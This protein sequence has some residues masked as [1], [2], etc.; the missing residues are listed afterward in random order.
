MQLYERTIEEIIDIL[1]KR[2]MYES[3]DLILVNFPIETYGNAISPLNTILA[4]ARKYAY[5]LY[6][7]TYFAERVNKHINQMRPEKGEI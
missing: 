3:I 2:R 7:F 6:E 4:A 1:G 5:A